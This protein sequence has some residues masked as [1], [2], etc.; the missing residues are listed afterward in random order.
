MKKVL[1]VL[2]S[3]ICIVAVIGVTM[4]IA[5]NY[6]SDPAKIKNMKPPMRTYLM[7]PIYQVTE[8]VAELLPKKP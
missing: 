1:K 8:A 4:N 3:I 2:I 5:G 6:K 7:I